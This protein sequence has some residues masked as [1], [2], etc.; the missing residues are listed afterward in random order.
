MR[1]RRMIVMLAAAASLS[2]GLPLA[3][4]SA[5]PVAYSTAGVPAAAEVAAVSTAQIGSPGISAP[6]S[7][8]AHGSNP[9]GGAIPLIKWNPLCSGSTTWVLLFE[10]L[11]PSRGVSH[12]CFGYTGTWNFPSSGEDQ[13]TYLCAGNNYGSIE[14]KWQGYVTYYSFGPGTHITWQPGSATLISLTITGWS[15]SD[16]C[17]V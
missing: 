11:L 12:W 10:F 1:F 6:S 9:A 17:T 15:G 7:G 13:A 8:A 4:A 14:V 16:R 3:A 5:A 2:L